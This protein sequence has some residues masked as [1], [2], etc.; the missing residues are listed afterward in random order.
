MFRTL[1]V[2]YDGPARGGEAIALAEVLRDPRHGSLLLTSAYLPTPVPAA[3]Y[4]IA[5]PM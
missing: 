1:V 5:P 2:G 3:P 4:V